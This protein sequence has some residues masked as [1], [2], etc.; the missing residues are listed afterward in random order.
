M[1][2]KIAGLIVILVLVIICV[3]AGIGIGYGI[4]LHYGSSG[5]IIRPNGGGDANLNYCSGGGFCGAYYDCSTQWQMADEATPD[6]Y[7]SYVE[8]HLY[9]SYDLYN[10]DDP[11]QIYDRIVS[12][13]V[14][15]VSRAWYCPTNAAVCRGADTW[16]VNLVKTHGEIYYSSKFELKWNTDIRPSGWSEC[17]TTF[18]V[19][20]STQQA[21]TWDE[22]NA[23][24]A[25]PML[26]CKY[27]QSPWT[28]TLCT[29]FYVTV[30]YKT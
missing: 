4:Y 8:D 20:P 27:P 1:K 15:Q 28:G 9:D 18:Q 26:H 21:W 11:T 5:V 23:L 19:N 3:G 13:V 16:C 10:F 6:Y 7:A 17:S 25:G 29:Q 22:I 24:E 30:N 14:T 12:I 2:R